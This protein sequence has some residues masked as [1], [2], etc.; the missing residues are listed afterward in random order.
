MQE[1][2]SDFDLFWIGHQNID[3]VFDIIVNDF[4]PVLGI[5][6]TEHLDPVI[7]LFQHVNEPWADI[8]RVGVFETVSLVCG[9]MT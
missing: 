2:H 1:I 6:G 7:F 3:S 5:A 9:W 8:G 4:G